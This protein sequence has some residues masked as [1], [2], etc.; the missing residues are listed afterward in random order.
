[1]NDVNFRM[2]FL[3]RVSVLLREAGIEHSFRQYKSSHQPTVERNYLHLDWGNDIFTE[4]EWV[5]DKVT[6][7]TWS[8]N[9][10]DKPFATRNHRAYVVINSSDPNLF[11]K[12]VD[13]CAEL[14]RKYG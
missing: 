8:M 5:G 4:I 10:A 14:G 9:D 6:I 1:M 2:A 12:I 13:T 3:N 7:G 11:Q